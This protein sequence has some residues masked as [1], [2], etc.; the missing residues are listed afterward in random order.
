[1]KQLFFLLV[2]AL[3]LSACSNDVDETIANNTDNA[4]ILKLKYQ[5]QN[6]V[7][8]FTRTF[9]NNFINGQK[10]YLILDSSGSGN[11]RIEFKYNSDNHLINI[12]YSENSSVYSTY[13]IEWDNGYIIRVRAVEGSDVIMNRTYSYLQLGV[14][15][16]Q[17][18]FTIPVYN[19]SSNRYIKDITLHSNLA[20]TKIYAQYNFFNFRR[21]FNPTP[22]YEGDGGSEQIFTYNGNNLSSVNTHAVTS[23]S[24]HPQN[25]S[26][27]EENSQCRFTRISGMTDPVKELSEKILGAPMLSLGLEPEDTLYY[28]NEIFSYDT[29]GVG[30][31]NAWGMS[32]YRLLKTGS[33]EYGYLAPATHATADYYVKKD[34]T[35]TE[36]ASNLPYYKRDITADSQNRIKTVRYYNTSNNQTLL[37]TTVYYP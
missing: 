1:M 20:R 31:N 24:H 15:T 19:I 35:T 11:G 6:P 33:Y 26:S 13:F 16:L 18:I 12:I 4:V 37:L 3:T 30:N 36:S 2:I 23:Y 8:E 10:G 32:N 7:Y 21:A 34:G 17:T 9:R 27:L 28:I 25:I 5:S 22:E 14:D 29:Y